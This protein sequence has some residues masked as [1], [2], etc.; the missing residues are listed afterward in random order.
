MCSSRHTIWYLHFFTNN[1]NNPF[2][3]S[4]LSNSDGSKTL[5]VTNFSGDKAVYGNRVLSLDEY[6]INLISV[7]PNPVLDKLFI[8]GIEELNNFSIAIFNINGKQVLSLNNSEVSRKSLNVEK[9]TKGLYFILF[10]DKLGQFAMKK[11]IKK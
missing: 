7:Y 10:E 2:E 5:T 3:Y 1:L 11:F 6:S 9:L 8:S 4:I